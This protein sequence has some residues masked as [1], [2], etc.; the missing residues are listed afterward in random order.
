MSGNSRRTGADIV[1]DE[2]SAHG[3]TVLFA[4][5]GTSEMALVRAAARTDR[6]RPVL[7]LFE[8]VATGAADGFCRMSGRPAATMLHLG[9]GLANGLANLHNAKRAFSPVINIVGDHA[10]SHRELDAPLTSDI[11]TAAAPFSVGVRDI[12]SKAYLRAEV[13]L[14]A[15]QAMSN[16]GGPVTAILPADIAW[17]ECDDPSYPSQVTERYRPDAQRIKAAAEKLKSCGNKALLL[18]SGTAIASEQG[19]MLVHQISQETGCRIALPTFNARIARGGGLPDLPKIP[20]FAEMAQQFLAG[21]DLVVCLGTDEPVSFFAYPGMASRLL[22]P[23]CAKIDLECRGDESAECLIHFAK[24]LRVET[25]APPQY[26]QSDKHD[27][28]LGALTPASVAASLARH[29]PKN[30]IIVD[31]AATSSL[32]LFPATSQAN[33]HDWLQLTGGSIGQAL[34]VAIGA[35]IAAPE[36][37]VITLSGDGS[38]MYTIQAL[39]TQAREKLNIVTVIYANRDYSILKVEMARTSLPGES[40]QEDIVSDLLSIGRPNLDFA[41]IARA[42]GIEAGVATTADEF[43]KQLKRA[44]AF[45]GPVLIEAVI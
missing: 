3:V 34:P 28:P 7:C 39:W 9:P 8:G 26:L 44:V 38:A 43:D 29:M 1:L 42:C 45:D 40:P 19:V 33:R 24:T 27:A 35:A 16:G 12:R 17:S 22:P 25:V 11:A 10:L 15:Q 2:L 30:A 21:I 20:Y 31:E 32:P 37:R 6:I 36:R 14:I 4:N 5:P 18:V 13:S 23:N 41:G